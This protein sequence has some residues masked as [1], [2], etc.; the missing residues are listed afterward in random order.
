MPTHRRFGSLARA[1]RGLVGRMLSKRTRPFCTLSH[2]SWWRCPSQTKPELQSPSQ[3][4]FRASS[5]A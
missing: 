5:M 2:F 1:V 4:A 3:R